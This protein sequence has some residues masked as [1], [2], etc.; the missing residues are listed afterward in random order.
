MHKKN[1]KLNPKSWRFLDFG[2]DDFRK[3]APMINP[4]SDENPPIRIQNPYQHSRID[5]LKN[6][7]CHFDLF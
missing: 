4:L 3:G 1:Q 7:D 5:F 6:N 2:T